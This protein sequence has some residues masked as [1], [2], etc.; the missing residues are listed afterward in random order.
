MIVEFV[1]LLALIIVTVIAI[2]AAYRVSMAKIDCYTEIVESIPIEPYT[3]SIGD[4]IRLKGNTYDSI[5]HRIVD[6]R[7]G[8][9]WCD[10]DITIPHSC[11]NR[12]EKF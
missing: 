11:Q 4:R 10:T 3:F 9:Y 12:Y 8:C 5:G 7:E 1:C 6:I 2:L